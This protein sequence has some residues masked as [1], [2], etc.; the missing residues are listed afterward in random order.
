MTQPIDLRQI[1]RHQQARV[2]LVEDNEHL[3]AKLNK[4]WSEQT[5]L[6]IGPQQEK[7]QFLKSLINRIG[8]F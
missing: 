7:K 4:I 3:G 5:C 1:K 2:L 8:M 6:Y